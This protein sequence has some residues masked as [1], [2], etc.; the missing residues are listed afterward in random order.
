MEAF[1]LAKLSYQMTTYNTFAGL[2]ER[3]KQSE[4]DSNL[5]KHKNF[6]L[7]N[8]SDLHVLILTCF[9]FCLVVAS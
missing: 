6:R 1:R 9:S 8:I 4:N 7:G 2:I 3:D 5:T